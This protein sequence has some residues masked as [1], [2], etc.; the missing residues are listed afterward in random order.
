MC[1][2][3]DNNAIGHLE[4]TVDGTSLQQLEKYRVLSPIFNMVIQDDN[5]LGAPS[6]PTKM[7]SAWLLR[8]FGT[9]SCL[10]S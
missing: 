5:P 3:A 2:R 9:A 1:A 6:G 8:F 7:V 4:A 10:E